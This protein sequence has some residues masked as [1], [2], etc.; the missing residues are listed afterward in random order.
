MLALS[1]IDSVIADAAGVGSANTAIRRVMS[2]ATTDSEGKDALRVTLVLSDNL[3]TVPDSILD[4]LV[5][6]QHK[7]QDLGE[8]RFPIVEFATEEELDSSADSE[9]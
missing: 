7:L 8:N 2:E 6:I 3:K 4:L 1:E 5:K 9:S